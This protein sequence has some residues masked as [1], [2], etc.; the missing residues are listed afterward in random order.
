MLYNLL[1]FLHCRDAVEKTALEVLPRSY[2][3]DFPSFSAESSSLC[4]SRADGTSF[5][6]YSALEQH[7]TPVKN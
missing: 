6:S 3:D 5:D 2:M 7:C 1:G 4:Q